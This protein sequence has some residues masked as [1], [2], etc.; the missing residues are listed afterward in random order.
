MEITISATSTIRFRRWSR[1]AYA[2]FA[3]IG[4]CVT[5]GCLRKNV[6]DCSLSKQ[7]HAGTS[8]YARCCV[9]DIRKNKKED[10]SRFRQSFH[11]IIQKKLMTPS[12]H[13]KKRGLSVFRRTGRQQNS[14][15]ASIQQSNH[16][17]TDYRHLYNLF[18]GYRFSVIRAFVIK[19]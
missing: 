13:T 3:S 12:V 17:G 15:F 11:P 5:I 14:V 10:I 9:D 16:I 1:K 8:G 18:A 6:V 2:A 7:K 19:K 4:R